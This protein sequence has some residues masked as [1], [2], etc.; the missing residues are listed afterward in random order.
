MKTTAAFIFSTVLS[1]TAM[2]ILSVLV[3]YGMIVANM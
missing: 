1:V 3:A 2:S